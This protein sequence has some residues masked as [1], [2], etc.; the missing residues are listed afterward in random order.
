[1]ATS[2]GFGLL[3]SIARGDASLSFL[4]ENGV[5][6]SYFQGKE[7]QAFRFLHSYF[8][9]HGGYPQ[10]DTVGLEI[11]NPTC[12]E[13]LPDEPPSYW[14]QKV[15][16]RKRH[17]ISRTAL[18]TI[19]ENLEEDRV[20]QAV[21]YFADTYGRL[22]ETYRNLRVKDL[23]EAER[24]VI[25][26]HNDVQNLR[27][28]P[29]IP[30]GFPYIDA[31][32]GGGQPGD[33]IVLVGLTGAGKTYLSL[34]MALTGWYSGA[35]V[36]YLCTEMPV[37]QVA[38]RLLAMEG[39]FDATNLK[40]GRMSAFGVQRALSIVDSRLQVEGTETGNFFKLLPGGLYSS[41]DDIFVISKE[42]NPGPS[43]KFLLVLD[44]ASLIRMPS[45]R[46]GR[47]ERMI[48]VM[49]AV[50]QFDMTERIA[51]ISTYHFNKSQPGTVE[52]IYGGL[53]MGQLASIV[54]SF[55]FER[56]EDRDSSNPVQYRILKLLKGRDGE[57]GK[58]RVLYNMLRTRIEQDRVL[59][60]YQAILDRDHEDDDAP[61]VDHEAVAEI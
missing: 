35:N 37:E 33:S 54:M 26:R 53:A 42:L 16:L 24:D 58:I 59:S 41:L 61:Y 60:G 43:G 4:T 18:Q 11:D 21:Q 23:R 28:V 15:Q 29:G 8:L 52:G 47:W 49:E 7:K 44:G 38:R 55:E 36:L 5:D 27:T 13:G 6:E 14:L 48:E 56:K 39:S 3:R 30:F 32:S 22:R 17:D 50:K 45:F 31:V 20:E 25:V 57:S 2:I 12:F 1:M 46:G 10:L 34:K 19:R 40:M 51:S 9:D